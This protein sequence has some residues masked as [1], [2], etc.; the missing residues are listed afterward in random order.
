MFRGAK[1]VTVTHDVFVGNLPPD[2]NEKLLTKRF[3]SY[4][5]IQSL[6]VFN[7]KHGAG[8]LAYVRY[9]LESD[10]D[11]ACR[12]NQGLEIRGKKVLVR[13]SKKGGASDAGDVEGIRK[14]SFGRSSKEGYNSPDIVPQSDL[15]DKRSQGSDSD[16]SQLGD[17]NKEEQVVVTHVESVISLWVQTIT[18][19]SA[20]GLRNMTKKLEQT[21]PAASKVKSTPVSGKHY[22]TQYS[23][24]GCWYRCSVRQLHS[25]KGK[26]KVLYVDFGNLEEKALDDLVEIP[27]S[28]ANVK[29]FAKKIVLHGLAVKNDIDSQTGLQFVQEKTEGRVLKARLTTP[30]RDNTGSFGDLY[31]DD[32]SLSEMVMQRGFA[33][34]T[35][36][37]TKA[38]T[39]R[40]QGAI[41]GSPH[42]VT[43][44]NSQL[45][46]SERN[47][48]SRN[49]LADY[50][51]WLEREKAEKDMLSFELATLKGKLKCLQAEQAATTTKT[52][53]NT[54]EQKLTNITTLVQKVT[55]LRKQFPSNDSVN[56]CIS[57][58][59]SIAMATD[60]VTLESISSL[61]SVNETLEAYT[62]CQ[63]AIRASKSLEGLTD[64]IE[65]RD[66][67]RRDLHA[68]FQQFIEESSK[69]PLD[70]RMTKVK[71]GLQSIA[72]SYSGFMHF[73][74][75]NKPSLEEAKNMY[76]DW[77]VKVLAGFRDIREQTDAVKQTLTTT[78]YH[79]QQLISLEDVGQSGSVN[80]DLDGMFKNYIAALQKELT[81]T[82]VQHSSEACQMA[83]I[84]HEIKRVFE[85]EWKIIESVKSLATEFTRQ[86]AAIEEWLNEKPDLQDIRGV[87]KNLR[88]IKSKLRH[89]LADK[90]DIE[91]NDS[92]SDDEKNRIETE[93]VA[94][95]GDLQ[96]A[97]LVEEELMMKYSALAEDH[98][99]ELKLTNADLNLDMCQ[100]YGGML[101]LSRDI[102]HYTLEPAADQ[103]GVY[104]VMFGDRRAV[105]REYVVDDRIHSSKDEFLQR[106]LRYSRVSS[107]YLCPVEAVLLSKNQKQVYV[108]TQASGLPLLDFV[109]RE[110]L[111]PWLIQKILRCVT[112]GLCALHEAGITH[113]AL[114]PQTV[115]ITE[116][117]VAQLAVLDFSR[118]AADPSRSWFITNAGLHFKAPEEDP[119]QPPTPSSDLFHLGLL[120]LWIHMPHAKLS[121]NEAGIPVITDLLISQD[122][123]H[124]IHN[125]L[126]GQPS[127]RVIAREVLHAEYFSNTIPDLLHVETQ[128]LGD[129]CSDIVEKSDDFSVTSKVDHIRKAPAIEEQTGDLQSGHILPLD[130]DSALQPEDIIPEQDVCPP[131]GGA[132]EV[133]S[134]TL[135]TSAEALLISVAQ[136]T[137]KTIASPLQSPEVVC[138]LLSVVVQ[139]CSCVN[140]PSE[141]S[142]MDTPSEC[143]FMDTPSECSSMNTPLECSSLN[144]PSECSF[145]D[146]PL[147]CSSMN[148]LLECSSMNTPSECGSMNTPLECNS[149]NTPLECNSMNTSS[150]FNT[151]NKPHTLPAIVDKTIPTSTAQLNKSTSVEPLS[152]ATG[153]PTSGVQDPISNVSVDSIMATSGALAENLSLLTFNGPGNPACVQLPGVGTDN[154][155]LEHPNSS[156]DFTVDQNTMDTLTSM[157][158]Q[159]PPLDGSGDAKDS[160][161]LSTPA[162]A[163]D[164]TT[165]MQNL[166]N[167]STQHNT[168]NLGF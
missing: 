1:S 18:E 120:C 109:E 92:G 110:D 118:P 129:R 73:I 39:P 71:S 43:L 113:G 144:T 93:L 53:E 44:N 108:Q 21:C 58:S 102:D 81:V 20:E 28:L 168:K 87:R 135:E 2:T 31:V 8:K 80:F 64:L 105:I 33:R 106:A 141:C 17:V 76:N 163:L 146:T 142:F 62:S 40:G 75:N 5:E 54:L 116:G 35:M 15:S 56:D 9:Y 128:S 66:K 143:S 29:P 88:S 99:P 115:L 114:S 111:K 150:E 59:L 74:I 98:F 46:Y 70:G 55:Q 61:H 4:G 13:R 36:L 11:D 140:T 91:E 69:M 47:R 84:I 79:L 153:D 139:E 63:Q 136:E 97:L 24:D 165:L 6:S 155:L 117:K 107:P 49:E 161:G 123:R 152:T 133:K 148:T 100:T 151:M 42:R 137:E 101:K 131:P 52:A 72:E 160:S 82:D 86:K 57:T 119:S 156:G 124:V 90:E 68:S 45:T 122:V 37:P 134:V 154:L 7:N 48:T 158:T 22:A 130:S 16:L 166:L 78:L 25:I 149:M 138:E 34:R 10:A 51:M 27:Q 85:E 121:T 89:L 112:E 41:N 65:L 32:C 60:H 162:L 167:I 164:N 95:R 159:L 26:V 145:M 104:D 50:K 147:E 67:R 103:Q 96:T 127:S 12:G 126:L 14:H 23:Q 30:L 38:S 83:S 3:N 157:A 94:I 77:R 125:L 19:Q 132:A